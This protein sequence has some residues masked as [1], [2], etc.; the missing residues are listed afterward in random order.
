[1]YIINNNNNS[2]CVRV[3]S[4]IVTVKF[5]WKDKDRAL[6]LVDDIMMMGRTKKEETVTIA[7]C[8]CNLQ[9]VQMLTAQQHQQATYQSY[10][11]PFLDRR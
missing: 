9:A 11:I 3:R 2:S 1:M 6:C 10:K 5:R 4:S 8:G 7:H